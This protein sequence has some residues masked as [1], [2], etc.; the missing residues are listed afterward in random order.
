[1]AFSENLN[2]KEL[3]AYNVNMY[4]EKTSLFK[5]NFTQ[6]LNNSL[7]INLKKNQTH[8][9]VIVSMSQKYVSKISLWILYLKSNHFS[10]KGT[11]K[12]S[13]LFISGISSALVALAGAAC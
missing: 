3:F 13:F 6:L 12:L 2:F 7:K 10:F 5:Y 9:D 8:I 4:K 1:M 11:L